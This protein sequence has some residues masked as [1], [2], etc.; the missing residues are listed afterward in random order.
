MLLRRG[1]G[2][3]TRGRPFCQAR[4]LPAAS[5]QGA[6]VGGVNRGGRGR[7]PVEQG[8]SVCTDGRNVRGGGLVLALMVIA[9][10][11][12]MIAA[13]LDRTLLLLLV[14]RPGRMTK[15]WCRCG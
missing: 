1:C 7:V 11:I 2:A 13:F 12:V 15:Q 14:L 4:R 10:V 9:L 6:Q 5:F 8:G 3:L